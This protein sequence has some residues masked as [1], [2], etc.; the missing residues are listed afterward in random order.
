MAIYAEGNVTTQVV[1][2]DRANRTS[3]A[4][5][6]KSGTAGALV[7][8]TINGFSRTITS[9]DGLT[10]TSSY[11]ALLRPNAVTDSRGNT[12][13]TAYVPGTKLPHTVTNAAGDTSVTSYDAL[14]RVQWQRD[15]KSYFTQYSYNTRDQLV[16][17]W[18]TGAMPVEYGY[19]D[20]Y[21]QRTTLKTFR[22]GTGWG[23][24]GP[25]PAP[26]PQPIDWPTNPGTADTTTWTYD[27][28]SGL[29]T[30]KI[31]PAADP[32]SSDPALNQPKSVTQT[33]NQRGQTAS[34]TLARGT[35]T[36]YT[37][38]NAT[39][40]LLSQTYSDSTPSVSYTY[41][42]TGQVET[43]A[44]YTGTHD[45]VYDANKPWRMTAEAHSSFYGHRV[46]TRL[47]DETGTIGRVRGLQLG[48]TV[49]S[50][51]EL[52]QTFGFTTVGRFETI[53]TKRE[54]N[55]SARTFRYGYLEN[56][57]MLE[58]VAID[59]GAGPGGHP[60]TI[61]RSYETQRNVLTIL[62]AKWGSA[63]G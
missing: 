19:D 52:E 24:L 50:N 33:Y 57:A 1:D 37:Y 11:D 58:S 61:T 5:T 46:L 62:E 2:I 38:D 13:A 32:S 3:T 53:A 34:R 30:A 26:D 41:G 4:T 45:L 16:R 8:T 60:F 42:R 44:D 9:F 43:V 35:Q 22:N 40:E 47:Y 48:P 29:L 63:A 18:G 10:S 31:Y 39:G 36:F 51:A 21:G 28:P 7:E 14:G 17:Q 12:S 23:D 6:T 54:A 25:S 55:A 49:G 15:P 20:V 56:T 59:D 27:P